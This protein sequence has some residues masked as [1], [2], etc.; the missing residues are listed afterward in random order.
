MHKH[1]DTLLKEEDMIQAIVEG[2][3]ELYHC[4][5]STN[6]FG[7]GAFLC[8]QESSNKAVTYRTKLLAQDMYTL[9]ANFTEYISSWIST[10]PSVSISAVLLQVDGACLLLVESF[11]DPECG[12]V[13]AEGV[14]TDTFK[15]MINLDVKSNELTILIGGA[16]GVVVMVLALFCCVVFIIIIPMVLLWKKLKPVKSDRYM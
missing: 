10:S 14:T 15:S 8:F 6:H 2:V 9:T 3:K 5:F 4:G 12:V 11:G 13:T 1:L 7:G 16:V